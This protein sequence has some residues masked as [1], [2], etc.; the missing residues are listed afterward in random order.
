[1]DITYMPAPLT[2]AGRFVAKGMTYDWDP[3]GAGSLSFY[4]GG[5][6]VILE[7]LPVEHNGLF[8]ISNRPGLKIWVDQVL[9]GQYE[10]V[11]HRIELRH[12]RAG[13][14]EALRSWATQAAL[15]R[16]KAL[17]KLG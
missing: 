10:V 14:E 7:V 16:K 6:E 13:V 8:G 12:L 5:A 9:I 11:T 15:T 3:E 17:A 4:L 2:R 1:M